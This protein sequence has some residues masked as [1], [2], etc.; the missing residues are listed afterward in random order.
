LLREICYWHILQGS[1]VKNNKKDLIVH[2]PETQVAVL[3]AVGA[4]IGVGQLLDSKEPITWRATAGRAIVTGGLSASTLVLTY[5][6][7]NMPL[8]LQLG[9]GAAVASIGTDFIINFA[10]KHLKGFFR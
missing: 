8:V 10:R 7:P 2:T 1:Q 3:G 5:W 9:V 6:I 4:V